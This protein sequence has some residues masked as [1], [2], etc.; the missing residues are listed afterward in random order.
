[1]LLA[2]SI[3]AELAAVVLASIANMKCYDE[4]I[5]CAAPEYLLE[6]TNCHRIAVDRDVHGHEIEHHF[7]ERDSILNSLL[8]TSPVNV[9]AKPSNG[10]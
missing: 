6:E 2:L 7:L 1:M 10:T 5:R 8:H 9:Y 4:P 3:C